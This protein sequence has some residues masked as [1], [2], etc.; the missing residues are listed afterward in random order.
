MINRVNKPPFKVDEVFDACVSSFQSSEVREKYNR[1][2]NKVLTEETLM[3]GNLEANN[4]HEI[5]MYKTFLLVDDFKKLYKSK[6]VTS[7][8]GKPYYDRLRKLAN[9]NICPICNLDRVTQL[10]HYYPQSIFTYLSITP[11]NLYP[12]CYECNKNKSD[13]ISNIYNKTFVNPYFEDYNDLEWLKCKLVINPTHIS[14]LY[15]V[16]NTVDFNGRIKY[17]FDKLKLQERYGVAANNIF[18]NFHNYYKMLANS[19]TSNLRDF[20][21]SQ[22]LGFLHSSNQ[23]NHYNKELFIAMLDQYDELLVFLQS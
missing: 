21:E 22:S 1:E 14:F 23:K 7:K 12:I 11:L 6:L 3:E 15:Y 13:L 18:S 10:D 20:I 19:S 16:D 8:P 9:N 4:P 2:R 5:N 17:I